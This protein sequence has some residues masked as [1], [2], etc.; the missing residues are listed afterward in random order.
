MSASALAKTYGLMAVTFF[1]IDLLWL[2]IVARPFYQ[3]QLGP[4]LRPDVRWGPAILFYL[5]FIAGILV[6]AVLPGVERGSLGRAVVLGAFFGFV[7]YATYDLTSLALVKGFTDLVA[8][9][10]MTWGTVLTA[11]V[12]AAGYAAARWVGAGS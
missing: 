6:F 1:A 12:A 5:L 2:G 10:D 11:T 3:S 9:V 4:M 8:V 7:A